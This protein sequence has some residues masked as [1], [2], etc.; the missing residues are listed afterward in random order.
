MGKVP[1]EL[2]VLLQECKQTNK[3]KYTRVMFLSYTSLGQLNCS[4]FLLEKPHEV[5]ADERSLAPSYWH[6]MW[7]RALRES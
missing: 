3:D 6:Q 7:H 4:E 1:G 5:E 2:P